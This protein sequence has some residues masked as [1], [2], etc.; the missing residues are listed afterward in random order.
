MAPS[1]R[2]IDY[3]LRPAKHAERLMLCEAFR[4]LRFHGMDDYQYVGL[5][6]IYFSDFR[7]VH[8][9]LGISKLFSIEKQ[10]NDSDRFEWNKPFASIQMLFGGTNKRLSDIDF[11]KPTITWLDY[12]GPLNSAVIGDIRLIAHSACHGSV[13]IVTVN[14]QPRKDSDQGANMLDQIRA[15]LGEA[16]V[17]S[18]ADIQSLRG[19]G[20]AEFY[21]GVAGSEL[22]DALSNANAVSADGHI[23]YSQIFNFQ[24][25]DGAKMSTFG[26]VFWKNDRREEFDACNF[27]RLGF[28]RS[29]DKAFRITTPKLTIR[30]INHIERQLPLPHG[31]VLDLGPIPEKDA[32]EYMKLYR[33]LPAFFP[34]ELS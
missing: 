22:L 32:N 1:Y 3:R 19:W 31:A 23:C 4:H 8:K 14:S 29:G 33:F 20:L 21:R 6:S 12:D 34:V 5:G 16:R 9:T 28:M 10:E 15:E 18:T 13:L 30:E 11:T 27:G 2:S 26:G 17:P 24:Y 7:M 25:E